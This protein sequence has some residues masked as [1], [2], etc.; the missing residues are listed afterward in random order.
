MKTY[1]NDEIKELLTLNTPL[2]DEFD[3][4][5]D[6]VCLTDGT[7]S[8]I[9]ANI[10]GSSND[11][12]IVIIDEKI[13]LPQRWNLSSYNEELARFGPVGTLKGAQELVA[14]NYKANL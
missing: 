7:D 5:E 11:G 6:D 14:K 10:Y 4:L 2:P 13:L 3:S 9:V 8:Y 12:Y 1:T